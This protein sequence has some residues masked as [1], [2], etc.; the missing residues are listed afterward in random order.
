MSPPRVR[1]QFPQLRTT[2]ARLRERP[3]REAACRYCAEEHDPR[4][5]LRHHFG[6]P[7][8]RKVGDL[9]QEEIVR[10]GLRGE[11]LLAI[12]PTGAGKS[13][14]YQLPALVRHRRRGLLTIVVSPLQALMRDQVESLARLDSV[15]PG[16]AAYLNGL[17]TPPERGQVLENVRLGYTALLYVAPEQLRNRS[18]A[19]TI[20]QREIGS[21]VFDE[22][23]C[24]SKWGH[25]FRPDYLYAGR[26]IRAFCKGQGVE[27][28]PV[29]CY[30]A[31]ARQSVREEITSYFRIELRTEL[32]LFEAPVSR[33]NLHFHVERLA[34]AEKLPRVEEILQAELGSGSGVVFCATR[35][36]A[37]QFARFLRERGH[38]C[39]PFHAGLDVPAK[40]RIQEEFLRGDVRV[41]CATN[42]FGMGIDKSDIRVVVHADIPGSIENYLQEA[43]RAGRDGRDASCTLLFTPDDLETQFQLASLSEVSLHDLREILNA[44]RRRARQDGRPSC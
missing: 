31:T 43:G 10:S 13:I 16:A 17:L 2:L 11:S 24:I 14:C 3:C 42:A 38:S 39:D 25:D 7:G 41:V 30:T 34:E 5:Q 27:V 33:D 21:W 35:R 32:R 15:G 12:L 36:R 26:F 1:K 19:R 23:H 29:A 8:F 9:D 28:A 37:E 44:L 4:A 22:A 20:A 40:R 18:F 6:H